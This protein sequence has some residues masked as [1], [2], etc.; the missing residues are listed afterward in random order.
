MGGC[1]CLVM[2]G[3]EFFVL[4]DTKQVAVGLS[5]TCVLRTS[6]VVQCWGRNHVGQL[7]TGATQSFL[8]TPS[9]IV[10]SNVTAIDAGKF[11]TCALLLDKTVRCWGDNTL[12]QL[13]DISLSSEFSRTPAAVLPLTNVVQLVCGFDFACALQAD[14]KVYCWG[15][16]QGAQLGLGTQVLGANAPVFVVGGVKQISA[17]DAHTC[18]VFAVT[19]F[20]RCWGWNALGQLGNG[21]TI[22]Q[23]TLPA[24]PVSDLT[25]PA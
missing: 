14:G 12:G 24:Q 16:G 2:V 1:S 22:M 23:W 19:G 20:M 9:G 8:N 6:G 15:D 21:D 17:G 25:Y 10:L 5:H 18:V 13:G 7:G 11:F 3:H 4:T